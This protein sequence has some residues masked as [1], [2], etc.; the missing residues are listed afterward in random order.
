V[1]EMFGLDDV[2]AG[3]KDAIARGVISFD[4]APTT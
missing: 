3:V 1:L 2:L 4:T